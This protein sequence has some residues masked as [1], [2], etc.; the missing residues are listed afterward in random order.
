MGLKIRRVTQTKYKLLFASLAIMALAVQPLYGFVA[1]RVANAVAVQDT[2]KTSNDGAFTVIASC[3]KNNKVKVTAGVSADGLNSKWLYGTADYS[4]DGHKSSTHTV[5]AHDNDSWTTDLNEYKVFSVNSTVKV[6]GV[7]GKSSFPYVGSLSKSYSLDISHSCD[8]I[9]PTAEVSYSKTTPTN[10][11]IYAYLKPSEKVDMISTNWEARPDGT[12]RKAYSPNSK[13]PNWDQV[14]EFKDMAGN[15]GSAH[16]YI[17]WLDNTAPTAKIDAPVL[18]NEKDP[19]ISGV[20]ADSQSGVKSHWF[21]IKAPNGTLY[22]VSGKDNFNLSEAKDNSD[23]KKPIVITD[24][25]YRIRYV[26]TDKAG[27][28]SDDPNYTN[29]TYHTTKIDTVAPSK[30]VIN[31]HGGSIKGTQKFTISS[32]DNDTKVSADSNEGTLINNSD[33]TWSLDTTEMN[34]NTEVKITATAT[35]AAG[36]TSSTTATYIVKNDA[37]VLTVNDAKTTSAESV[38]SGTVSPVTDKTNVVVVFGGVEHPAD[39]DLNGNWTVTLD[40]RNLRAGSTYGYAV[41]ANDGYNNTSKFTGSLTVARVVSGN[42]FNEI[43][44]RRGVNLVADPTSSNNS[45]DANRVTDRSVALNTDDEETDTL[46]DSTANAAGGEDVKGAADEKAQ[47][48]LAWYW[49][50]LI[51]AA[52]AAIWWWIAAARK[53]N[54]DA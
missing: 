33:G 12:F 5:S 40:V 50:A 9:K 31:P 8:D 25:D 30:P 7:Y 49:W 44:S 29:P 18:T 17:D 21:E 47:S 2:V 15:I 11:S 46:G 6:S 28:R 10:G 35:D 3:D 36:N 48:G 1:S 51:V 54:Q 43:G 45:L 37:P 53:R 4:I 41:I 26:V 52:V 22:Y 32:P 42:S 27:N 38:V 14:A 20:A 13:T 39:I 24:G 23:E 19:R 34:R 16:V